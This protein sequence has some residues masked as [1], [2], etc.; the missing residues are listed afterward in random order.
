MDFSVVVDDLP[1]LIHWDILK[2]R[3]FA[4]NNL[5]SNALKFVSNGGRVL[6]RV[7]INA[8]GDVLISIA[9]N[10]PGIPPEERTVIFERFAQ[11]SNNTRSFSGS[12]Y[13]LFNAAHMV[14]SH[15]G[16]ITITD[17]LDGKGV[18]FNMQIPAIPFPMDKIAIF[19]DMP[20][21]PNNPN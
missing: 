1:E 17:G 2:L 7:G 16:E 8:E 3:Y 12:G 11:A 20:N 9:D 13:G 18:C 15:F 6:V 14:R 5:I 21:S 19:N 4:V 10:G